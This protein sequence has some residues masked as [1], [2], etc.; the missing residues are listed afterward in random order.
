MIL[1]SLTFKPTTYRAISGVIGLDGD[2]SASLQTI[3]VELRAPGD[4]APLLTFDLP[5]GGV[6]TLNHIPDS[7]Y[8]IAF[9]GANTLRRVVPSVDLTSGDKTGLTVALEPGDANDD[10]FCDATD[11]GLLVGTYGSSAAIPGSGYDPAEDFNF[12][13][14]VDT[15]DFGLLVGSYGQRGDK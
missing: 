11:F 7:V 10:N 3:H 4:T 5:A 8:D 1:D 12:D 13:G 14:F 15:S 9:K 2:A 6:F